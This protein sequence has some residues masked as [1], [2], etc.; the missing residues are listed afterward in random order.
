MR[1]H[2]FRAFLRTLSALF[3]DLTSKTVYCVI[4]GFTVFYDNVDES[5][6]NINYRNN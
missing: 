1:T 6:I 4:Y 3:N 5:L 2:I